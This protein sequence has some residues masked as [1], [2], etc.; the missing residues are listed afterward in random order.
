MNIINKPRGTG[1]T[2]ELI[3]ASEVTG[4]RIITRSETQ[5]RCVLQKSKELGCHIPTPYSIDKYKSCN[6]SEEVA[7][8]EDILIDD[9]DWSLDDILK[10]YFN[11][12]VFAVTMSVKESGDSND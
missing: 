11:H 6:H 4:A 1:K 8:D 5:A 7:D 2:V 10:D 12:N 9:L 3:Y